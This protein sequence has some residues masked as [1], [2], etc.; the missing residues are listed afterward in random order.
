MIPDAES[1]GASSFDFRQ[2]Y[3]RAAGAFIED[4]QADYALAAVD[5]D[6]APPRLG[7]RFTA[8]RDGIFRPLAGVGSQVM[9][10]RP[11]RQPFPLAATDCRR[12]RHGRWM[13]TRKQAAIRASLRLNCGSYS[14]VIAEPPSRA[15]SS[16]DL[17]GARK[18]LPVAA[19]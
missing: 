14:L 6:T 1:F 10:C 2:V 18:K 19:S 3:R 15:G 11:R 7:P 16:E 12:D 13:S 4:R 17:I 8:A 5:G 9:L